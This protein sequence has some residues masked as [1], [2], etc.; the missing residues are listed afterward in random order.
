[1]SA[2]VDAAAELILKRGLNISVRDIAA[3]ANVNHGLVHTY[4]G[5]K[6]ALL[7][8]ALDD[9]NARAAENSTR[10]GFPTT[11]PNDEHL[12]ELARAFARVTLDAPNDP[13]T[14]HP[15]VD[16]WREALAEAEPHLGRDEVDARVIIA[17]SLGLGWALF[18]DHL[19]KVFGLSPERRA[20]VDER[21]AT[22]VADVGGVP[23]HLRP[24]ARSTTGAA[25]APQHD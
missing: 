16:G 17:A 15:M 18:S 21:V 7:T 25:A 8:A 3:A 11:D 22:M 23:E 12:R 5:S 9:L 14:S 10:S 2:L 24:R 6:E 20:L 19:A 1:M 4:F 13:F